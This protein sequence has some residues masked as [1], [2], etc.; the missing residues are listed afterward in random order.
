MYNSTSTMAPRS[1][2]LD[3]IHTL[4]N[5]LTSPPA[6]APITALI[7][8]FTTVPTPIIHEHGLPQL[9]PFLGRTFTGQDGIARY[10][11]LLTEYLSISNMTFESD[12]AWLVDE[13]C[14]AVSLRG[15]ATFTWKSTQ[16]GWDETFVYRIALAEEAG[17]DARPGL[18]I[19]EYRVWAD[20]GAA[21][22][23]RL[24]RLGDLGTYSDEG[25]HVPGEKGGGQEY[26]VIEGQT[27][28]AI[29]RKRSGCQDVL[30]GGLNVYGSCG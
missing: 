14:M 16:Q 23:A 30:G 20:S 11:E 6:H 5:A 27:R 7:S 4:L 12:D 9:A 28:K 1:T 21:Y 15:S 18:K 26:R 10:F 24:G 29:D 22:L 25:I 19:Y 8:T 13:S 2:L 3:P 17:P